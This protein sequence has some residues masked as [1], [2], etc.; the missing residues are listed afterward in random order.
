MSN[1]SIEEKNLRR[2]EIILKVM[3]VIFIVAALRFYIDLKIGAN[4]EYEY[5]RKDSPDGE[6]T[7][8]F[9]RIGNERPLRGNRYRVVVFAKGA[10]EK[11]SSFEIKND[12]GFS[13]DAAEDEDTGSRRLNFQWEEDGIWII[14]TYLAVGTEKIFVPT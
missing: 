5:Y 11:V 13:F 6:R 3:T 2:R 1:N 10:E 8:V 12:G 7:V 4:K 14:Y 9:Y